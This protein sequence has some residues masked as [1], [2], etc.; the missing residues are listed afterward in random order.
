MHNAEGSTDFISTERN[1]DRNAVALAAFEIEFG[2]AWLSGL[3]LGKQCFKFRGRF[4]RE[5]ASSL[6]CR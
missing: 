1:I 5:T 4:G 3:R 2:S 6:D